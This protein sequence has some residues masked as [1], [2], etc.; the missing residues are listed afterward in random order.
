M[1]WEVTK[2]IIEQYHENQLEITNL[3]LQKI[4]YFIQERSAKE[5]HR[6]AFENEM[7]AWTYGPVFPE[8]YNLYSIFG[9]DNITNFIEM[10]LNAD[11]TN[12]PMDLNNIVNSEIE[13]TQKIS[14]TWNLVRESHADG[15]IWSKIT[16]GGSSVSY[17]IIPGEALL[18]D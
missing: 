13:R 10:D 8:V 18:G 4:L 1:I 3:R 7:Q 12:I 9:R 11:K 6:L 17:Q 14:N 15:K 5:L 2:R 16:N